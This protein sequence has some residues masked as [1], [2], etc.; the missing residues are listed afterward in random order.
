MKEITYPFTAWTLTPGFAP[1]EVELVERG[2]YDGCHATSAGKHYLDSELH[3]SKSACIW[4]GWKRIDEQ[5]AALEKRA[6]A[7]N[8]KKS[9]LT[10]HSLK[11]E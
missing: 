3:P 11:P 6:D 2:Y 4:A 5:Q 7:I 10:K 9:T 8:K 1:K